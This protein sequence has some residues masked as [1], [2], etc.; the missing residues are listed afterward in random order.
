MARKR[1]LRDAAEPARQ[2]A[3][4]LPTDLRP[5]PPHTGFEETLGLENP[6]LR[7]WS[8]CNQHSLSRQRRVAPRLLWREGPQGAALLAALGTTHAPGHILEPGIPTA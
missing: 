1:C 6:R 7:L 4:W 5:P 2:H 8:A 3:K